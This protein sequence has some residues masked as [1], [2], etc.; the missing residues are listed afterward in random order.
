[1]QASSS[2]ILRIRIRYITR[3]RLLEVYGHPS[4]DF[5]LYRS[6]SIKSD[7]LHV[8]F[9]KTAVETQSSWEWTNGRQKL[10]IFQRRKS[11]SPSYL[12]TQKET[13]HSI[14]PTVFLLRF[15]CLAS[16]QNHRFHIVVLK[17]HLASKNDI[18]PVR[19]CPFTASGFF[20]EHSKRFVNEFGYL[21]VLPNSNLP[22]S[23]VWIGHNIELAE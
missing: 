17:I 16:S 4:S 1:M 6:G 9:L 2:P 12:K 18:W 23:P 19:Y 20:M 10:Q 8:N 21:N 11:A 5:W 13:T 7:S 14:I 3:R 22:N 15:V